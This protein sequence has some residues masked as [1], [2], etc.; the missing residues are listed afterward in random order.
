MKDNREKAY[1]ECLDILPN[2]CKSILLLS[3]R[4]GKTRIGIGYIK[5]HNLKKILWVTPTV[6]LRDEDIPGE[7]VTW[8]AK[9]YLS[10]ATIVCYSSLSAVEGEFDVVILDEIQAITEANTLP[11]FNG[12]IK[13]KS[14]LGL[15]GTMPK[16]FEKLQL[17]KK[18][19]LNVEKEI[20]IDDA[21][22]ENM[23]ADYK[24]NVLE[25]PLDSTTKNVKGGTKAKPFMTTEAAAYAYHSKNV[26]RMMFVNNPQRLQH[27]ILNRL[28]FVYNSP[29]KLETA[30]KLIKYLN[31]RKLVFAG[32]IAHAEQLSPHTYHSKTTQDDLNLFLQEKIDLLAC[33]NAGGTGFTYRNVDHFIIVQADSNKSGG[34]I[35]KLARSLLLQKDY[36]ASI[37]VISLQ[38]TQD[39][40]WITNALSELNQDKIEYVNIKNLKL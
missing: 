1:Q 39:E 32:S 26:A 16:H 6:K 25:V 8:K 11:F 38:G 15:T 21:V 4:V 10:G 2:P 3:P 27:A 36:V 22:Q 23:V 31:G 18:L 7:F 35:Q 28:R 30:K 12:K 17:I 29:T 19:G 20:T 13:A 14:I 5:K 37:W 34:F 9:S 24:V 33:V 40:Q